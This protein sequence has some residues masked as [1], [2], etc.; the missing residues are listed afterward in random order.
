MQKTW[1]RFAAL[2]AAVVGVSAYSTSA[3]ITGFSDFGPVN[4]SGPGQN[5]ISL[6]ASA[7]EVTDGQSN[8]VVSAWNTLPQSITAFTASYTYQA[9]GDSSWLGDGSTIAFQNPTTGGMTALGVGGGGLGYAGITNGSAAI[10]LNLYNGEE[11]Y[12]GGSELSTGG[13]QG[14]LNNLN[15]INLSTGDTMIVRLSYSGTTLTQTIA[16]L[17]TG[18]AASQT[19]TGVNLA[20]IVGSNAALVGIT[21]ATDGNASTQTISNFLFKTLPASATYSPIGVTGFTQS[22]IVPAGTASAT[23][24]ITA[25]M[26]DGVLKGGDTFFEQGAD[27]SNPTAGLPASGSTFV[28]Q[29]DPNH[30]FQMQSYSGPDA[31]LLG[32]ANPTGTLTLTQP[33]AYGGLSILV[34]DG[35]GNEPF[36]VTVNFANGT[37]ETIDGAVS[38]DWFNNGTVAWTAQERID[39]D[40]GSFENDG[41]NPNLYQVDLGLN[42]QVDPISSLTFTFDGASGD[43]SNMAIFAVSGVAVPE[44]SADVLFA[45]TALGLSLRPRVR[46]VH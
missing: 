5:S 34:A 44:P 31:L 29:N 17:A 39:V 45:V 16:D 13:Q 19:Y 38:P 36:D 23:G 24:T 7:F 6:N 41:N 9:T 8:E 42:D 11:S 33:Q 26:D 2:G 27:A 32:A 40:N 20:S 22:L 28:S 43:S 35:N 21:G 10:G 1:R 14:P 18:A 46:R 4:I 25:T 3:D 15:N 12:Q 30:I 37:S